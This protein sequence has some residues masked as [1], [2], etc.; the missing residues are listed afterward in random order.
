MEYIDSNP[1]YSSMQ[2]EMVAREAVLSVISSIELP[3]F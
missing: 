1:M 3:A 2:T